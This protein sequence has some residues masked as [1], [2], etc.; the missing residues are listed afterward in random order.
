MT[1]AITTSPSRV[2]GTVDCGGAQIRA[3]C[4]HLATVVTIRGEI[5]AV[6]V[7]QVSEHVR[8]FILGNSPVVLDLTDLSRFDV[9]GLSLLCA[10]DADCR[11]AGLEWTLVPNPAILEL[12]GDGCEPDHDEAAFP[13]ARS[14]HEALRNLAEAIGRRRQLVLPLL[15]KMA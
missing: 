1:I 4:R 2:N 15:R 10:L 12:L 11:A 7:D 13:I 14:V 5:D 6:N 3:H 9:A 8:R